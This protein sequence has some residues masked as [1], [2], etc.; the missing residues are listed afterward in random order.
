MSITSADLEF[1]FSNPQASAGNQ[2]AQAD[3]A[4]SLG[5]YLATTV[6]AGGVLHDLFAAVSGQA[7]LDLTVDYR[8]L[9]IVNKHP[10]L[11]WTAAK[12]WFVTQQSGGCSLAL[13]VD[14]TSA[15]ALDTA[16]PAVQAVKTVDPYTAPAGVTFSTPTSSGSGLSL[17]N[18]PPG[19]ARAFW[20]RRTAFNTPALAGDNT[21]IRVEGNT[22]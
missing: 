18:I 2:L 20:L 4:A 11:T 12:V 6:W 3:P 9:F 22:V 15:K 21:T 19:C 14:P 16:A 17:G 7:N 10:S 5:G 1:R 8:C 13:G